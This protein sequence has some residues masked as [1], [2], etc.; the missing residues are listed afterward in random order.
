MAG[1]GGGHIDMR[2][3]YAAIG[4]SGLAFVGL[5]AA[6][7]AWREQMEPGVR[8]LMRGIGLSDYGPADYLYAEGMSALMALISF[9][10]LVRA[11]WLRKPTE[12]RIDAYL[13]ERLPRHEAGRDPEG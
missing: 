9:V 7:V 6:L 10:V 13:R 5:T 4:L 11:L 3:R 1:W 12:R 2:L 8:L